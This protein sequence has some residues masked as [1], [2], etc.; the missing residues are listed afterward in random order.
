[1]T[2]W[3]VLHAVPNPSGC[4]RQ[5]AD[6]G[7]VWRS[8]A[9]TTSSQQLEGVGHLMG[10][11]SVH[12]GLPR[13]S[14]LQRRTADHHD[15]HLACRTIAERVRRSPSSRNCELSPFLRRRTGVK[16][17]KIT[18]KSNNRSTLIMAL[19]CTIHCCSCRVNKCSRSGRNFIACSVRIT[20]SR[21]K[22]R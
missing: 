15:A 6:G 5:T 18:R 19:R 16:R 4:L 9:Q 12:H 21:R 13:P 20:T 7:V 10:P 1:M 17:Q 11:S 3:C 8:A 22:K 2:G 14:R